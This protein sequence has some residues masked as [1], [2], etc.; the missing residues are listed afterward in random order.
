M[1]SPGQAA[2][3]IEVDRLD[4]ALGID[5]TGELREDRI[6]LPTLDHLGHGGARC[7]HHLR[8]RLVVIAGGD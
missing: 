6:V 7:V 5:V 3:W 2:G 8:G 4:P 1:M